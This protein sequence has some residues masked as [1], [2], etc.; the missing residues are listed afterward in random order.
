DTVVDPNHP[1]AILAEVIPR[2]NWG[3]LMLENADDQGFLLVDAERRQLLFEGD[4]QRYRIPADAI[5]SCDVEAMNKGS[6]NDSRSVPV[7]LV[8][9][10]FRDDRLGEREVPFLP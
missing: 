6:E 8:V 4:K 9:V 7:A 5:L 1:D 3:Q 2:R 10:S